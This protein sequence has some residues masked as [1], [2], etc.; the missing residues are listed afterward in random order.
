MYWNR[1]YA[2]ALITE[3]M[4]RDRYI[5][6]RNSLKLVHDLD[7]T[8]EERQK[9]K[10]WKV[11]YIL[12]R[13]IRGCRAQERYQKISIDEMIIPFTGACPIRQYC[14]GKPHPPGLKAFVLANSNGLVCD[15][16]VYQ[17]ST[18]FEESE[19]G[20]S[21][22]ENVVLKLTETL[23]PGHVIYC[24]RYFT[25]FKLI[26]ELNSRG[27]KC[28]GMIMKNRIPGYL[29]ND[30]ESDKCLSRRGRG[31]YT[32]SLRPKRFSHQVVRL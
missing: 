27:F 14:P 17:G 32:L 3:A 15:M 19:A 30:L 21:L 25:T 10:L 6:L 13:I 12:D 7:V 20:H 5:Q 23:V 16:L 9:D 18:T 28:A 22:C 29:R 11:R 1:K 2:I 8:A 4:S 24:D 26:E 31:S